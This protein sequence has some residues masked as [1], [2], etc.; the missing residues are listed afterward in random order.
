MRNAFLQKGDCGLFPE[1]RMYKRP[2]I[3]GSREIN[4]SS[5]TTGVADMVQRIGGNS[6]NIFFTQSILNIFKNGRSHPGHISERAFV[7]GDCFILAAANWL[8]AYEDFGWLYEELKTTDLPIFIIG[9]GTQTTVDMEIPPLRP[10]TLNLLRLV[11]ERS[12]L[13]STRG[14]FSC[15]VLEHYGIKNVC[16]TGCPSLLLCGENGPII[17]KKPKTGRIALHGTRHTLNLPDLFQQYIYRQALKQDFDIILQSEYEDIQFVMDCS[18]TASPKE[19]LEKLCGWYGASDIISLR[20]Y[21]NKHGHFFYNTTDWLSY[22]KSCDFVLGT[23]IHGTIAS[24]IAGTPA[25]LIAHDPRTLELALTM[26]I[27]YCLMSD[28]DIRH[29]IDIEKVKSEYWN[30]FVVDG[31]SK[32]WA[33]FINFFAQNQLEIL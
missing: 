12:C 2:L 18:G 19:I 3:I 32:Y 9:I 8:N 15:R 31:Y 17:T 23:R 11:S 5:E 14:R 28:I 6:G 13:I 10:G 30:E 24:L 26:N 27:P 1:V 7:D 25:V 22:I 29:D 20:E 33:K 21:L 16:D 4:L